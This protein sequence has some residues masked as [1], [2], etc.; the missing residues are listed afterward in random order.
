MFSSYLT[1]AK[2]ESFS[3]CLSCTDLFSCWIW[4]VLHRAALK[5]CSPIQP[6]FK[7]DY[8]GCP[9]QGQSI[10]KTSVKGRSSRSHFY[11]LSYGCPCSKECCTSV[12]FLRDKYK[13]EMWDE[14]EMEQR[15]STR[16]KLGNIVV[17]WFVLIDVVHT[18]LRDIT[19]S[20]HWTKWTTSIY[21]RK[22]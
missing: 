17:L 2:M 3:D 14:Q 9:C 13:Q 8:F 5:K 19:R 21:L 18:V 4:R 11:L 6:S 7:Y 16:I 12:F 1:F 22:C 20:D 10:G 15:S